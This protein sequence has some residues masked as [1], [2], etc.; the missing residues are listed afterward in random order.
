MTQRVTDARDRDA[1]FFAAAEMTHR[2]TCF[3]PALPR[4]DPWPT[5]CV[6]PAPSYKP[7]LQHLS[8]AITVVQGIPQATLIGIC[9][10][11]HPGTGHL[12]L[13]LCLFPAGTSCLRYSCHYMQ[14]LSETC[15]LRHTCTRPQ[16]LPC[17]S[18]TSVNN[19]CIQSHCLARHACPY[20]LVPCVTPFTRHL[21]LINTYFTPVS[22]NRT[23]TLYIMRREKHLFLASDQNTRDC[24]SHTFLSN[25]K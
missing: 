1:E 5:Y 12:C 18:R 7:H 13:A 6:W 10:L 22:R 2:R 11:R 23:H 3:P 17:L 15:L 19:T 24:V 8:S 25:P 9:F 4:R 14:L 16:H 21:L 20:I